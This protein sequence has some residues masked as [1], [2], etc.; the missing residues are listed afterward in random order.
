[1]RSSFCAILNIF[2]IWN[3]R[4]ASFK[5]DYYSFSVVPPCINRRYEPP[6]KRFVPLLLGTWKKMLFRYKVTGKN[7][8]I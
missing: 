2:K 1:M 7:Q 6:G 8:F 5:L 3:K 4:N